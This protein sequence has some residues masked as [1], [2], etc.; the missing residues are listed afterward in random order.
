[1]DGDEEVE[2][3]GAAEREEKSFEERESS[4][5]VEAEEAVEGPGL[6]DNRLNLPKNPPPPPAAPL[7]APF[8]AR[9]C[10]GLSLDDAG[11]EAT[12]EELEGGGEL[13]SARSTGSKM[14]RP[15]NSTPRLANFATRWSVPA[16]ARTLASASSPEQRRRER[17][18]EGSPRNAPASVTTVG[19]TE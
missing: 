7:V 14:A 8:V 6:N 18:S 11:G 10:V 9:D 17:E 2:G 5:E 16:V 3:E 12:P 1:L 13:A 4:A 15:V 19:K